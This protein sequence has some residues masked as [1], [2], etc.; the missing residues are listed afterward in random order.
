M[1]IF[2]SQDKGDGP[3]KVITPSIQ[4]N[5]DWKG[6][7]DAITEESH[8]GFIIR[9]IMSGKVEHLT[10]IEAELKRLNSPLVIEGSNYRYV[11]VGNKIFNIDSNDVESFYSASRRTKRATYKEWLRINNK[12]K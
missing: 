5:R 4:F 6:L 11:A 3:I 2:L 1:I 7:A 12:K 8:F 9:Q 10:V